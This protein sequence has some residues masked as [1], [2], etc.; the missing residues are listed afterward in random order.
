MYFCGKFGILM[1]KID[2]KKLEKIE[3]ST[4]TF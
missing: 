3:M 4:A 2:D 1:I